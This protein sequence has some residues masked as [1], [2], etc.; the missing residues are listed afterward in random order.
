MWPTPLSNTTLNLDHYL[1]DLRSRYSIHYHTGLACELTPAL[2]LF[3]K[4]LFSYDVPKAEGGVWDSWPSTFTAAEGFIM[5]LK[6]SLPDES[7]DPA[8]D[9]R[10]WVLLLLSRVLC[11]GGRACGMPFAVALA[12]LG[13]LRGFETVAV[14][15]GTIE[16]LLF[17]LLL[18]VFT[19]PPATLPSACIWFAMICSIVKSRP[20]F[21]SSMP[22]TRWAIVRPLSVS[23]EKSISI[24]L[25]LA[26]L[27]LLLM[28]ASFV[29]EQS[30]SDTPVSAVAVLG[31]RLRPIPSRWLLVKW[32]VFIMPL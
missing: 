7:W 22:F 13:M 2:C 1:I 29:V 11:W 15:A 27:L 25:A 8:L 31:V 3:P 14:T 23:D 5:S 10:G 16:G 18:I 12:V 30:P 9:D 20:S 24:L 21:A 19:L 32:R 26:L 4:W 28:L 17:L 6:K